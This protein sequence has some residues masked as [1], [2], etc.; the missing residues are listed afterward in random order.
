MSMNFVERH[1]TP[2]SAGIDWLT[3]SKDEVRPGDAWD[4]L[5]TSLL[6]GSLE[7]DEKIRLATWM[8][9]AG[10]KSSTMFYGWMARRAVV[11]MSGPHS[12]AHTCKL[13]QIAS[14]V[15]RIDLQL[16]VKHEPA[17]PR[18]GS[19]NYR[20]A[21]SYEGR[22][23][24][25]PIVSEIHDTRHS[26]TVAIGSRISD[27]Y[28]RHYDKG[29]ESKTAAAGEVWRYEVEYKRSMA[30]KIAEQISLCDKVVDVA[31]RAVWKWW[32]SRGILPAAREPK[33]CL[34]DIRHPARTE[35]SYLEY[36]ESKVARSVRRA[37]AQ[38]GVRPVLRAL[39]LLAEVESNQ[40]K[41]NE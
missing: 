30:K 11:W 6:H 18:L 17:D 19:I 14:N 33:G 35:P 15:S 4:E 40:W 7:D 13:I 32:A 34:I 22:P 29:I 28:G 9:Y 36:F 3:C 10:L 16:T 37:T 26:H 2:L 24:V 20:R 21:A 31:G 27:Q 23:G 8:G 1:E 12:P 39:G 38:H 41:E 5:A 25:R